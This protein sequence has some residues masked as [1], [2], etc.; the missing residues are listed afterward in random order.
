MYGLS[1]SDKSETKEKIEKYKSYISRNGISY[2]DKYSNLVF[3]PFEKFTK[4][5]WHNS[6]KYIS[7]IQNRVSSLEKY[8]IDENLTNLFITITLPSSYHKTKILKSGKIINNPKFINDEEHTPNAGSK[9]LS[10]FWKRILDLRPLKDLDKSKRCYFRVTEPH[11]NGTPH[12][13]ISLYVPKGS[14]SNILNSIFNLYTFPQID[15]SSQ[16]IPDGY[17]QFFDKTLQKTVYKKSFDDNFGITTL[18]NNPTAYLM[19]YILKTFDDLRKDY[20][21][22]SDLTLWY[23]YHGINRFST[24]KTLIPLYIYRRINYL[25]K[26]QDM[27]EATKY[28]NS[29]RFIFS[30]SAHEKID[31]VSGEIKTRRILN[32][33]EFIERWYNSDIETSITWTRMP[34]VKSDI[35][36]FI[37]EYEFIP[38]EIEKIEKNIK[39]GRL[40]DILNRIENIIDDEEIV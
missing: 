37:D 9:K 34:N 35:D 2:I 16:Y 20:S 39:D 8:A 22:I 33:I 30:Y 28:Y 29:K 1:A 23:I 14:I 26:F 3:T 11:K 5:A 31:W 15:I 17:K 32:Q 12:L 21:K 6:D 10:K 24:S 7:E 40:L 18:I 4:N 25:K 19:K 36:Y 13:H 27:Y 38:I